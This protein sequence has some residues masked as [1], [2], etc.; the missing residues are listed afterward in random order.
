MY[1]SKSKYLEAQMLNIFIVKNISNASF[2]AVAMTMM[3]AH[4]VRQWL[5][6]ILKYYKINA[7]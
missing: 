1:E 5:L 7:N 6:G 4:E 3:R 2:K